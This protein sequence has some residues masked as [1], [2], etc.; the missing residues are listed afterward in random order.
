VNYF[1]VLGIPSDATDAEITAAYRALAKRFHPDQH[2]GASPS[3]KHQ[4]AKAMSRINTAYNTLKS[5]SARAEYLAWL[6]QQ[7][8][9]TQYRPPRSGECALCG[10][11]PAAWFRFDQ[12]K[13]WVIASALHT[14]EASLC[15]ECALSYGRAKQNSTLL[16]GWWGVL[17]PFRNIAAIFR[18]ARSLRVASTLGSPRGSAPD[19]VAMFPRPLHPGRSVFRRPGVWVSSIVVLIVGGIAAGSAS[20]SQPGWVVGSCVKGFT[21]ASPVSCSE[22]HDGRIVA[23]TSLAAACPSAAESYVEGDGSVYCIDE[24]R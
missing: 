7:I 8:T 18:N 3:E 4:F 19:V 6:Q 12:L 13:A 9:V 20:S 21:T 10:S 2:P 17:A 15:R 1:Q 11:S 5:A 23:I 24:D 16:T 22:P 14:A